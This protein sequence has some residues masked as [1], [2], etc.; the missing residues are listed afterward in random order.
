MAGSDFSRESYELSLTSGLK[1]T[2][3]REACRAHRNPP[4]AFR[5]FQLMPMCFL[6]LL[7][8]LMMTRAQWMLREQIL[9]FPFKSKEPSP[10]L[11]IEWTLETY[12]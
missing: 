1:G 8:C 9:S 6:K 5:P 12:G 11:G 4:V 10:S 2:F 7:H 3:V